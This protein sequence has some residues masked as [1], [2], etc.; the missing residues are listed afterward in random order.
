MSGKGTKGEDSSPLDRIFVFAAPFKDAL[1]ITISGIQFRFG[2]IVNCAYGIALLI[3]T[4]RL[5]GLIHGWAAAL[6][7][8]LVCNFM[9]TLIFGVINIGQIDTSFFY[10]YLLRNVL[11]TLLIFSV[12][13]SNVCYSDNLIDRFMTW[14]LILQVIACVFEYAFGKVLFMSALVD[15][16]YIVGIGIP[17]FCGTAS[18]AAYIAPTLAM[19][20]YYFWRRGRHLLASVSGFLL[21]ITFSSFSYFL[22]FIIIITLCLSGKKS[23]IISALAI[24]LC[25]FF[26]FVILGQIY[27]IGGDSSF[28]TYTFNKVLGFFT[29]G[30][31]GQL[32]WSAS[33]RIQQQRVALNLLT[34]ARPD[35]IL[36]GNG[37]GAVSQASSLAFS[38]VAGTF[39]E[40][41]EAYTLYLSTLS[42]RGIVGLLLLVLIIV[43]LIKMRRKTIASSALLVGILCQFCHFF[44]TGN[45]WQSL[46]WSEIVLFLGYSHSFDNHRNSRQVPWA[47]ERI[48]DN[49]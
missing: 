46:L 29:L 39:S 30:S 22:F 1:G 18:E 34:E 24:A 14:T 33:D 37:T 31:A 8:S 23:K 38:S 16:A 48:L 4:R 9:L 15:P 7:L 42:D 41:Q 28:I 44:L 11:N 6:L 40:A 12:I 25:V 13:V 17:R 21:L 20:L 5:N 45:L 35:Q 3:K 32:D 49:R 27:G 19:L 26:A 47:D 10:K 2:E 36:F 43:S